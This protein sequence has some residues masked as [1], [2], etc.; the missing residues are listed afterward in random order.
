MCWYIV[1]DV[2]KSQSDILE[3]VSDLK[4]ND[5][6]KDKLEESILDNHYQFEKNIGMADGFQCTNNSMNDLHHTANV[7]QC[8][9]RRNIF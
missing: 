4:E 5:N 6:L 3:I 7:T 2:Q 9:K 1:A 8:V